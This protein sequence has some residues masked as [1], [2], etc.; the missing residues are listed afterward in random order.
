MTI[1]LNDN[2]RHLLALGLVN[3]CYP[4]RLH[5]IAAMRELAVKVGCLHE[6]KVA[7]EECEEAGKRVTQRKGVT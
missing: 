7:C 5:R 3:L 1:E 2:D 6:F 4:A